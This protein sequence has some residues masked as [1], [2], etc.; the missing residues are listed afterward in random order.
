MTGTTHLCYILYITSTLHVATF[1]WI[2]LSCK[3]FMNARYQKLFRVEIFLVAV[4]AWMKYCAERTTYA[5]F[6]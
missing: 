6:Y 4:D 1:I 3:L 5:S 2:I